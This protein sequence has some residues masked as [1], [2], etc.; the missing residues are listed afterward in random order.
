MNRGRRYEAGG[1]LN[2]K[3]VIAVIIAIA[4]IIMVIVGLSKILNTKP[5]DNEKF[6]SI[7]KW[8]M[9]SY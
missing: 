2:I 9:G 8:K 4:V 5:K 6:F 1:E 7:Y 3:K